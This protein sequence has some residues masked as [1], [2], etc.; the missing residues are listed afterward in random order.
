[1]A[2]HPTMTEMRQV[3]LNQGQFHFQSIKLNKS[4]GWK[5]HKPRTKHYTLLAMEIKK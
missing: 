5:E 2:Q 3:H 4:F 1:M